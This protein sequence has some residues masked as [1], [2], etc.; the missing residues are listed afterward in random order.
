MSLQEVRQ[1]VG[2]QAITGAIGR[3]LKGE[4]AEIMVP[5][6]RGEPVVPSSVQG[7]AVV[8]QGEISRVAACIDIHPQP[9]TPGRAQVPGQV[10][11]G[12]TVF[13]RLVGKAQ[14]FSVEEID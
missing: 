1:D 4:L 8:P 12:E 6:D 13:D 3:L 2:G 14:Q 5:V 10:G 11:V 7:K 9:V